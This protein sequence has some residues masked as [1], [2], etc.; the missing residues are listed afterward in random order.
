MTENLIISLTSS[1]IGGLIGGFVSYYF[2]KEKIKFSKLHEERAKVI[3][4]LYEKLV[5]FEES[6]KSLTS[7]M[8]FYGDM[9]EK[10][11]LKMSREKGH[12]FEVYY[13]KNKIYFDK[14]ICDILEEILKEMKYSQITFSVY[15]DEIDATKINEPKEKWDERVSAWKRIVDKVPQ[16][17]EKLEEEFRIILVVN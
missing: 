8:K 16:L 17:K 3:K 6:M 13:R 14:K 4:E 5:I 7:P 9:K 15:P 11:K 1:I 12:E 10:E 2:F